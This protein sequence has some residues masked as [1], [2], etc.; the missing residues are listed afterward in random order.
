M[1]AVGDLSRMDARDGGGAARLMPELDEGTSDDGQRIIEPV[2]EGVVMYRPSSVGQ[3]D[4]AQMVHQLGQ[5][6]TRCDMRRRDGAAG[7]S[8]V[9]S[10][11]GNHDGPPSRWWVLEGQRSVGPRT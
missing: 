10:V 3:G 4:A 11:E 5:S 8:G 9:G 2:D 7:T 1:R 6:F